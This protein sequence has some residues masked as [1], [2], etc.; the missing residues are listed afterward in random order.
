MPMRRRPVASRDASE[1]ERIFRKH[2]LDFDPK[3]LA[4]KDSKTRRLSSKLASVMRGL[5]KLPGLRD[6]VD[7]GSEGRPF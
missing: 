1:L 3:R 6:L 2:G 4:A 7:D 5:E